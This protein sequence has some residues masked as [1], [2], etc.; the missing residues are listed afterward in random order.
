MIKH[1]E[2][3]RAHDILKSTLQKEVHLMR[4]ILANMHEEELS[5]LL[6][7]K[8]S[9]N[10]VMQHR[11]GL[12][13]R[14]STLRI[15]RMEATQRIE[16]LAQPDSNTKRPLS[17][18]EILPVDEVISCEILSLRDQVLALIER[19]NKQ[20]SRNEHLFKYAEYWHQNPHM[21]ARGPVPEERAKRKAAVATYQIK[22]IN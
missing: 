17:L 7:D 3:D 11:F 21:Y 22:R 8:G 5:L 12:I 19:M 18:E 6:N 14:L 20:N 9:W 1:P 2:W 10:Q 4:E 16:D 13:E 15:E